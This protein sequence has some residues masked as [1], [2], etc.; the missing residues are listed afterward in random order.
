MPSG[1]RWTRGELLIAMNLYHKL[2]F[3]QLDARNPVIIE[4]AGKLRRTPG[5]VAMKL[6]NFASLD[7]A[8]KLRGIKGLQGASA[9]DR[10][11]WDE[12]HQR[13]L[14]VIPETEEALGELFGAKDA[15]DIEVI[16][17][18]GIKISRKPPE[19]P[20]EIFAN[21]R[22]R[23]GQNYF[24]NAVINN[25]GG[26]CGVTGLPI[27]ELLVAS[28]IVPWS[29][30]EQERLNVRNGLCLNRLHDAAFDQGFIGFD[31]DLR[32]ILSPKLRKS[33]SE[34]SVK[35][36]FERYESVTLQVPKDGVL[37]DDAFLEI[38]RQ[39]WKLHVK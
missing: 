26:R 19:G 1:S 16:P 3:G 29:Q 25:F 13:P 17:K 34:Q 32:L 14:E 6:C 22:L 27:R 20:T 9:L 10:T 30:S 7:P 2:N 39:R 21:V 23:R 8:L 12:Y 24:R 18:V 11:V 35:D 36:E 5:S 37:P 31:D 38:H 15:S 28:H 33:V 4:L